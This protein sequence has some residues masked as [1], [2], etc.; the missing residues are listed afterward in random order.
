MYIETYMKIHEY[1]KINGDKFDFKILGKN[2]QA[3]K[4]LNAPCFSFSLFFRK[5][6]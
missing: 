5:K 3:K 6:I 1:M 4:M 2:K